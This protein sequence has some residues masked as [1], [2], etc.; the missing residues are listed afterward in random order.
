M[1]QSSRLSRQG[2]DRSQG[3][4]KSLPTQLWLTQPLTYVNFCFISTPQDRKT[5]SCLDTSQGPLFR[6]TQDTLFASQDLP[7][8]SMLT[9]QTENV[10]HQK[11]GHLCLRSDPP[12]RSLQC[13]YGCA[14]FQ[15]YVNKS[16]SR[17][18][19]PVWT[20]LRAHRL[21]SRDEF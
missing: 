6:A 1:R 16:V 5:G 8:R 3:S 4:Q 7:K 21:K 9:K 2:E 19:G 15:R 14:R 18:N 12:T 17:L 13:P 11:T 20:N 10:N